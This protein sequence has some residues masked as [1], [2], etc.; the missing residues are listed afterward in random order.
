[1]AGYLRCG[2]LQI[3][4]LCLFVL[5]SIKYYGA[6]CTSKRRGQVGGLGQQEFG[7]SSR[8]YGQQIE[9]F[10]PRGAGD[11]WDILEGDALE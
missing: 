8:G 3:R 1:M 4:H 10:G 2:A 7:E 5:V 11:S 6:C 9:R